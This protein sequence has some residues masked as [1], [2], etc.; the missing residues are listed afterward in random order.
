MTQ[1]DVR[2]AVTNARGHTI[3][4]L[5]GDQRAA[6]LA[7]A[8]G[9][10]T[11]ST[12][13][14]WQQVLA[15]QPWEL[16]VDV[17]AN[18]GEML[19]GVDLPAGAKIAAFEPEPRIRA[20]LDRSLAEAGLTVDVRS[21][22][23]SATAG[24]ASFFV[25]VAWS[26]TSRLA[27]TG[28]AG[29]GLREE[30]VTTTT[31]DLAL[32]DSTARTACI[33]IDVEGAEDLVLAGASSWFNRLDDVALVVEIL[34]RDPPELVSW[35]TGWRMY[36]FD[37]RSGQVDPCPP[38]WRRRHRAAAE[39]AVDLPPG[40]HPP[41]AGSQVM[42][43]EGPRRAVYTALM[44][45]YEALNEQPIA[46]R[47]GLPFICLTDSPRLTSTT[48]QIQLV[49]PALP[50]DPIR[51]A[52]QVKIVSPLLDEYDETLWIDNSVVLREA[53]ES[54]LETWLN[55]SD[56]T[57]PLHSFRAKLI[58]EFEA[59]VQAGFDDPSRVFEQLRHYLYARPE[60]LDAAPLWTGII[61]RRHTPAV[62][63][64][65][66]LWFTDVL[67]YS[68]RDQLSVLMALDRTKDLAWRSLELD[69]FTS[70]LHH[71]PVTVRRDRSG[72]LRGTLDATRPMALH[73]RNLERRDAELTHA[74]R[75]AS[76]DLEAARVHDRGPVAAPARVG[77]TSV[78]A[79]RRM[80]NGGDSNAAG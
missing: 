63:D 56:L 33:K 58:D 6:A 2:S 78:S 57:F 26:G 32:L 12:L 79:L 21:E 40:R 53:P 69:T 37:V 65:G 77:R 30:E 66:R 1:I 49:E 55:G 25:D 14:M 48:W 19:L 67:R 59:V 75:Q 28:P 3:Y 60:V 10:L 22:A 70:S 42:A 13:A 73:V 62:A 74:L 23:V 7:N 9:S 39:P 71:W 18:Y 80:E 35:S 15:S 20:C 52:R 5:E 38:R 45:E 31:L 64:F 29:D 46:E 51:S 68:R 8:G 11:P 4:L 36:F 76:A 43:S 54:I 17:G 72:P 61:A 47:S 16:V 50:A 24:V 44:G 34:H 27:A 41:A